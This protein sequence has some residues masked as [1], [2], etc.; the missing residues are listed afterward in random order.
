MSFVDITAARITFAAVLV[1]DER[2]AKPPQIAYEAAAVLNMSALDIVFYADPDAFV[3]PHTWPAELLINTV[4]AAARRRR[5]VNALI[6]GL[7][8]VEV[9]RDPTHIVAEI[10]RAAA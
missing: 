6:S 1:A 4:L 9:G 5:T 7:R 3:I 2:H 8:G 10:A